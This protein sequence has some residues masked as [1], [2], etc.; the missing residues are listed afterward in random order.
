MKKDWMILESQLDDIQ[1]RIINSTLDKSLIVSGCA[2]SG[3][4]VLA[5]IQAKRIEKEKGK[6]YQ[7]VVFTRA[8]CDYMNSGREALELSNTFLTKYAWQQYGTHSDYIIVDEIQDFEQGDIQSFI[9]STNKHFFFFGD[10]A[11]SVYKNFKNTVA[12]EDIQFVCSMNERPK[13]FELYNNY[14]LPVGV[15]KIAQYIGTDLSKFEESAYKSK[16]SAIPRILGYEDLDRQIAAIHRIVSRETVSDV[17]ILLPDNAI[18]K[19]VAEKLSAMG[20]NYEVRRQDK[21]NKKTIDTLNFQSSNPK[22]MTYFSA[23][24]L[25]FETVIIPC[26]ESFS[27]KDKSSLYVAM[28]RTYKDLFLMYSGNMPAILSA[29]PK[30]LYKVSETDIIE[31]L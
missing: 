25:Q 30:D 2:G 18:V 7:V 20:G 9:N 4:S 26:L 12:V 28:T 6:N 14:R 13:Y 1:F 27:D 15:A 31:D 24:G 16:E 22:I 23:K 21:E 19:E 3:K 8:L 5:L 11:Q 17:A 10:T 29:I